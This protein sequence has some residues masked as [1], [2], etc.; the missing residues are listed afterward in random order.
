M[1]IA[2]VYFLYENQWALEKLVVLPAG[3]HLAAVTIT[4]GLCH[5]VFVFL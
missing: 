4:Y 2:I 1:I 5:Y 3:L